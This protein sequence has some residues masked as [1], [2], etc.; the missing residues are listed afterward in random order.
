[1]TF[2][3]LA[4]QLKRDV[5]LLLGTVGDRKSQ[6][7]FKSQHQFWLDSQTAAKLGNGRERL[8]HIPLGFAPPNFPCYS[9]L[10]LQACLTLITETFQMHLDEALLLFSWLSWVRHSFLKRGQHHGGSAKNKEAP[11]QTLTSYWLEKNITYLYEKVGKC[12][13]I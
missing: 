2:I 12:I 3:S 1:M 13:L 6:E 7:A 5:E 11:K 4:R 9:Y 8:C 10:L